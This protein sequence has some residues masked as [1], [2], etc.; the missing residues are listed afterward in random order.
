MATLKTGPSNHDVSAFI[1]QVEDSV[2]RTDA[3]ALLTL[4]SK[5]TRRKPRMWGTSIVGFGS[6]CYTYAS[7][8]SGEWPTR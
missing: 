4:M 7:G 1:N 3:E 5:I 6:Y 8:H 2:S